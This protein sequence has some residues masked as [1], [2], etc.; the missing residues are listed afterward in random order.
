MPEGGTPLFC[1]YGTG[2]V[3]ILSPSSTPGLPR[4]PRGS[5]TPPQ[6]EAASITN[7][8]GSVIQYPQRLPFQGELSAQLTE[9]SRQAAAKRESPRRIRNCLRNLSDS[10]S[11]SHLPLKGE[12]LDCA[13]LPRLPFQGELSAQ[14]TERSRQAAAK[15]ESPRRIRNCLRNLSDSAPPSHLP[16]KGEA[17]DCA[18]LPRLPFQ[19]EALDCAYPQGSPFKGSCQRS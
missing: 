13:H 3:L 15:R 11:P 8:A 16:L 9:R 6:I 1:C 5:P 18:H 12:A 4:P 2:N 10:A 17:L 14:L 7:Q 19:G